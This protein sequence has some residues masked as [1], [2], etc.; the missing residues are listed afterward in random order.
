MKYKELR[1]T[2][3][4]KSS[5]SIIQCGEKLGNFLASAMSKEKELLEFHNRCCFKNYAYDLL[6]PFAIKNMYYSNSLYM[7][8]VKSIDIKFIEKLKGLLYGFEDKNFKFI[9]AEEKEVRYRPIEELIALTPVIVTFP[10]DKNGIVSDNEYKNMKN[11]VIKNLVRRYN[12]Y[13]G[14]NIHFDEVKDIFQSY[15]LKNKIL[16]IEYKGI[17][18][19]GVK[20]NIK[21]A[22][23]ELAQKLCFFAEATG[24]GEKS[25][26]CG[27][28]FMHAQYLKEGA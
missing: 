28:G 12:I 9:A 1:I 11:L 2:V 19:N 26:V 23:N 24:L 17:K 22:Q 5:F 27:S 13:T 10:K 14:E 18:L 7:F 8:R 20:M 3:L 15:N 25:S 21:P 6:Y 4:S 16:P